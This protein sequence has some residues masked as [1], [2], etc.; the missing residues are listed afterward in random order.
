LAL[1]DRSNVQLPHTVD[2]RC[3][4]RLS[5]F[6]VF[7]EGKLHIVLRVQLLAW[8]TLFSL[9]YTA[10]FFAF[11]YVFSERQSRREGVSERM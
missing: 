5:A 1:A 7:F 8:E 9:S 2:V 10:H 6:A 11:V 4:Q 3:P